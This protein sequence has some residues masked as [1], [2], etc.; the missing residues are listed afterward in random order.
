MQDIWYAT[1]VKGLLDPKGVMT[2]RLRCTALEQ[3]SLAGSEEG[4]CLL[5]Q[6]L[7]F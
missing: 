7:G 5:F 1:P 4:S 2:H 3:Q 6:E